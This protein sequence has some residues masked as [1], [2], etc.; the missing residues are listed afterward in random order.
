MRRFYQSL[1]G[2]AP[3]RVVLFTVLIVVAMA[4]LIFVFEQ[5]GDFLDDGGVISTLLT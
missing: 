1:P 3:V 2:P 5:A 4:L